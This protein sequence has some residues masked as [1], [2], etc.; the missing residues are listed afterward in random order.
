MTHQNASNYKLEPQ[1]S[2]LSLDPEE[3]SCDGTEQGFAQHNTT[4]ND[5]HKKSSI[6]IDDSSFSPSPGQNSH[7]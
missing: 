4:F 7:S 1:I 2:I 3:R 6:K 5:L